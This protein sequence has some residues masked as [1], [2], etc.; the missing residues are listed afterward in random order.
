MTPINLG[1]YPQ[2]GLGAAAFWTG[3]SLV[4]IL[5]LTVRVS[6]QRRAHRVSI[7]DGGHHSLMLA[8][9]TFGNATEYL[10]MGLVALTLI[11]LVGYPVSVIHALGAALFLGRVAHAIGMNSHKQPAFSRILGMILTYL[12]FLTA[13]A[14][15]IVSP[16]L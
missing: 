14:L 13:A 2:D 3:L 12:V 6:I 1:A 8:G 10:P 5:I 11:A 16:F 9:R 7:G 4:L 15:L